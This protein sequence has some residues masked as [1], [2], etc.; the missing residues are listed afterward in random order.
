MSIAKIQLQKS[1]WNNFCAPRMG[2]KRYT[3]FVLLKLARLSDTDDEIAKGLAHGA[4]ISWTPLPFTHLIIAALM[5]Y[6]TKS[7]PI[8]AMFGTAIGNPWT[9]P[10]MWWA[11]YKVGEFTFTLFGLH[12]QSMP[13]IFTWDSFVGAIS[14]NPW[15]LFI[16][17]LSGGVLL[18]LIT[19]PIFHILFLRLV[20]FARTIKRKK[21]I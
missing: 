16:P 7:S 20:I 1:F 19:W 15:E 12:M 9:L 14:S 8:A 2:W 13:S 21:Q 4:A 6:G 3:R 10:F 18:A 5:A 11:A 17:W